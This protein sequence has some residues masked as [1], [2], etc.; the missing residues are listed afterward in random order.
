MYDACECVIRYVKQTLL[1]LSPL[2]EV[3]TRACT[4]FV[5]F[6][7]CLGV[8]AKVSHALPRLVEFDKGFRTSSTLSSERPPQ[9]IILVQYA[10]TLIVVAVIV[11]NLLGLFNFTRNGFL[12]C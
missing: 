12:R 10:Q 4:R 9:E 2:R 11:V 3:L 1:S 5:A 6:N 7:T 8:P